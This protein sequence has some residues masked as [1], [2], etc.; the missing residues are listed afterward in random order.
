VV[1]T[2]HAISPRLAISSFANM[3]SSRRDR[4]ALRAPAVW[5]SR[6]KAARRRVWRS[7]FS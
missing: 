6:L 4:R 7:G 5:S 1:I 3:V 2:R